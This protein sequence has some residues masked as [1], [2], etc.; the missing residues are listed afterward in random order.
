MTRM[1]KNIS[2][3]EDIGNKIEEVLKDQTK[4][5]NVATKSTDGLFSKMFQWPMAPDL[6]RLTTHYTRISKDTK[7]PSLETFS[8]IMF[9]NFFRL[10]DRTMMHTPLFTVSPRLAKLHLEGVS[11]DENFWLGKDR[12]NHGLFLSRNSNAIRNK[13]RGQNTRIH[14]E[15]EWKK[16]LFDSARGAEVLNRTFEA[17][18]AGWLKIAPAIPTWRV[19]NRPLAKCSPRHPSTPPAPAAFQPPLKELGLGLG[20]LQYIIFFYFS[21]G[22]LCPSR[23]PPWMHLLCNFSAFWLQV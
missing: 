7:E 12:Q 21:Y 8:D 19:T 10:V 5:D 16:Y 20:H 9:P 13:I 14:S 23:H 3:D 6:A 4:R 17:F 22:P 2:T 1:R 18:A 15:D 11:C